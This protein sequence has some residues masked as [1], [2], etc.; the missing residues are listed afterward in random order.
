MGTMRV[1]LRAI[2]WNRLKLFV[3]VPNKIHT[4]GGYQGVRKR[5]LDQLTERGYLP[6][7]KVGLTQPTA[8][9]ERF[10]DLD[11]EADVPIIRNAV[12]T[13]G[14]GGWQKQL[15]DIFG[16]DQRFWDA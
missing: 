6:P 16:G 14:K 11:E 15:R 7:P 4:T 8:D 9:A 5:L 10:V 2:E 12:H 1:H 13:P 3:L